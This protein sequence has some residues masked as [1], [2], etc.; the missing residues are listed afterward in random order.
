V[1]PLGIAGAGIALC[2][3]YVVMLVAMYALTRGLFRVDFE[4]RRLALVVLVAGGASVAGAL[5]VP[6][7]GAGALLVR[8]ALAAAV[9][10]ALW[11]LGFFHRG[12]LEALGRFATRLRGEQR[13]AQGRGGAVQ[14]AADPGDPIR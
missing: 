7:H 8:T 1:P 10:P 4:W 5:L 9:L 3:A 13:R 12:E 2:I 11:A 6:D 14:E